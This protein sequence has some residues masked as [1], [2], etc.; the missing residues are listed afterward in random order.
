EEFERRL[1]ESQQTDREEKDLLRDSL[2]ERLPPQLAGLAERRQKLEAIQAE[3][4]AADA[5]RKKDGTDP[6]K[7]PAQ[8]PKHDP[9]SRVLPNKEGGY[10]P[11]YTPLATTEGHG[12]YIVD[13]DVIVGPNEHQELVPS[14]D[15]V[16]E[17]FGEKPERALADG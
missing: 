9:D 10:A 14:L 1:A 6:A 8:I 2:P 11:N 4:H 17:T 3:L 7:N 15:R 13:A 12:G 5:V 16:A